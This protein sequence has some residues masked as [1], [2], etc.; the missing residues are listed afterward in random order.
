MIANNIVVVDHD[1]KLSDHFRAAEFAC[2]E[3]NG[4]LIYID[5]KLIWILEALRRI[6][7]EPLYINVGNGGNDY[8]LKCG[9]AAVVSADTHN[10]DQLYYLLAFVPA[11]H[12]MTL[13]EGLWID[14]NF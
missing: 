11:E 4:P 1:A 12:K 5:P 8:L 9:M 6:I 13:A 3:E 14:S 2:E 10:P 7:G